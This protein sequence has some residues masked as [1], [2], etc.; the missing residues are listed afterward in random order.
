MVG[1]VAYYFEDGSKV[2][3]LLFHSEGKDRYL[4]VDDSVVK[5][6]VEVILC[7]AKINSKSVYN[8]AVYRTIFQTSRPRRT[9]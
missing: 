1:A 5:V 9:L 4:L 8:A 7:I 3:G 2:E 6:P